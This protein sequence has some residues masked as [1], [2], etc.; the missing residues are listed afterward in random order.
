MLMAA[1]GFCAALAGDTGEKIA[2]IADG[3]PRGLS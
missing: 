1:V 3:S 2:V